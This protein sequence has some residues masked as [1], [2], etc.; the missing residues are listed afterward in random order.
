MAVP[1]YEAVASDL[2][3]LGVKCAFG[4]MSD[5]TAFLV[6]TLD[7]MGVRFHAARHENNAI[8]MAEGYAS[9]TGGLAIAI[10]GRGPATANALHGA[11][12]AHR[13]GS[14]VL[15][16]FGHPSI[17]PASPD[18]YGPDT[19]AF[20]SVGVLRAAGLRTLMATD[21]ATA[22]Q[23]VR[24]AIAATHEGA[25]AL[26]LPMN[27]QN[28]MIDAAA[29]KPAPIAAP[30]RGPK[31]ARAPA[32][33][34]AAALLTKSCRPL[35]IAG[36]GAHVAG[37]RE[38]L[39]R[40][41][42][43]IGAALATT[44]KAK[45]MFRGHPI[46][47]GVL[48]SFSHSAGRRVIE[49]A[50]CIAAFGAALTQRTTSMGAAL[51]AHAPLIQVDDVRGNIGR[52]FPADVAVVG[53]ARIAAEQL[54]EALPERTGKP[55][56]DEATRF[57]LA[58]FDPASDFVAASTPRT[59]DPRSCAIE[60]DRLLPRDRNVVYDAGN[61][62]QAFAYLSVPGPANVKMTSDF[63]SV[64][65]GFGAALGFALGAPERTTVLVIGD[66]GLLMT[67]GEIE[68]V[69]REGVPIVIVVM[70]DCAY[71]AELHYL[72]ANDM[73]VASST[74][75]DVDFAPMAAA[76]G[77]ESATVRTLDELRALAPLLAAPDGPILIDCK[78]NA[79]VAAPFMDEATGARPRA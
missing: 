33:D 17:A 50:D 75:P 65:M 42:D 16:I 12:Y 53:D 27:V 49:Q 9:A 25:V 11:T 74:F 29:T 31:R 8:A 44:A 28:A 23:A 62:L 78:I 3:D 66:G 32:I 45:D 43:R 56:H 41:A 60:L 69:V 77:F 36:K 72:K 52:W 5:D 51:P 35:I 76:F 73:P 70:N 71:G 67:L 58:R 39:V 2:R 26:L 10:L 6:T 4:L 20:D 22:R 37:A 14:R 19:K 47:C 40:L 18:A 54:L 55:L 63:A 57:S 15:L 79:S 64:G 68:T 61:M 59:M 30:A 21:A 1:V 38:A 46:D 48:G 7:A 24:T 34:A 13:S